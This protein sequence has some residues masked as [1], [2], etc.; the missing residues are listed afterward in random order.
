MTTVRPDVAVEKGIIYLTAAD[1]DRLHRLIEGYRLGGREDRRN[2]DR[3]AEELDRAVVV[4]ASDL[5]PDVVA[6]DSRVHLV[7]LDAREKL[8][9]TVVLPARANFDEGRVSVLAPLGT[10]VL[11]YR[12]GDYIEWEVPGGRRRLRVKHVVQKWEAA[13]RPPPSWTEDTGTSYW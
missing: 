1:I 6:L 11:G 4:D 13:V 2:L 9:F 7:D 3:L 12:T 8:D 10:A 5:P